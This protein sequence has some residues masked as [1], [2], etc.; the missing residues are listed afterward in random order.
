[1]IASLSP[2]REPNRRTIFD[3]GA[4]SRSGVHSIWGFGFW[5]N[6]SNPDDQQ[7]HHRDA[8]GGRSGHRGR[9]PHAHS[10]GRGRAAASA[11][12]GGGVRAPRG[13]LYA[14]ATDKDNRAREDHWL[15][16][17]VQQAVHTQ[18]EAH[19][20]WRTPAARHHIFGAHHITIRASTRTTGS[21]VARC[22]SYISGGRVSAA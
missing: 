20:T 17:V 19:G 6:R 22:S 15:A 21:C 2:A 11:S 18:D 9:T 4:I 13:L 16:S 3:L 8:R 14:L 5:T 1:M 10:R 7:Q 12:A